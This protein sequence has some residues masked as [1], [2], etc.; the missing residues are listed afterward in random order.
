M[1]VHKIARLRATP[2]HAASDILIACLAFA[3]SLTGVTAKAA[4]VDGMAGW[5]DLGKGVLLQNQAHLRWTKDDNGRDI[6]WEEA[7]AYCSGKGTGW[8]LPTMAELT[9]LHAAAGQAGQHAKC[10][11]AICQA[12]PLF[13]LSSSWYW[14]GTALTR[15]ESEEFDELAWGLQLVNGRPTQ[16]LRFASYNSRA[17]C[18]RD[19]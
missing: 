16:A 19:Q 14:S 8:R 1:L 15:A 7:R 11:D 9:G 5:T 3:L 4:A 6:G 18:V 17:L 13:H 10:G 2:P 12:P